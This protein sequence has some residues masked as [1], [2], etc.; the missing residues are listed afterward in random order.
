MNDFPRKKLVDYELHRRDEDVT[1][2]HMLATKPRTLRQNPPTGGSLGKKQF[3]ST[4]VRNGIQKPLL[5]P[6]NC[7]I[8]QRPSYERSFIKEHFPQS[9]WNQEGKRNP[10]SLPNSDQEAHTQGRSSPLRGRV[11]CVIT[12]NN[13]CFKDDKYDAGSPIC[14]E[15]ELHGSSACNSSLLPLLERSAEENESPVLFQLKVPRK[16]QILLQRSSSMSDLR[17]RFQNQATSSPRSR[18][19]VIESMIS[20]PPSPLPSAVCT[21]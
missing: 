19:S 14:N 17:H 6:V 7:S 8:R 15:D 12:F 16:D 9:F 20:S 1:D 10:V 4:I 11:P 2:K 18:I 5:E 13:P 3:N 21:A